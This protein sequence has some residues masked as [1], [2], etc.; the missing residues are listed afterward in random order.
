[1]KTASNERPKKRRF[2]ILI[3]TGVVITILFTLVVFS[4]KNMITMASF[5]TSL[6]NKITSFDICCDYLADVLIEYKSLPWLLDY[7]KGNADAIKNDERS[8]L[9]LDD[10][11]PQLTR[12]GHAMPTEVTVEEAMSMSPE[13][14]L[15]F[16]KYCY[17]STQ[18][19]C[20]L[21]FPDSEVT[22]VLFVEASDNDDNK[23][24][25]FDSHP[26]ETDIPL[27]NVEDGIMFDT[28]FD[29]TI[30]AVY[31]NV[32]RWSFTTPNDMYFGI[33][34]TFSEYEKLQGYECYALFESSNIYEDM[35]FVS[36]TRNSVTTMLII[37]FAIILLFLYFIVPR[38]LE[39]LKKCVAEYA[40][41][42]DVQLLTKNLSHIHTNNEIADFA[43]EFSNLAQEMERHVKEVQL[44]AEEKQ[45]DKT[46]LEIA[47]S[48]QKQMM[49]QVFPGN[50][51]FA[52][53]AA[54]KPA[55]E[56][57]GDFYD[58]YMIDDDHLAL[59]IA[60]VSGKGVASALFMAMSKIML[61]NRTLLGGTPS[62]ILTDVNNWICEGNEN[63]MFVTVWHAI[64]TISTGELV[65]ANAGHEY[66]AIRFGEKP[67]EL[68]KT[69]HS[70]VL[71]A[72]DDLEFEDETYILSSG[73]ALFVYTDGVTE[74]QTADEAM[75]GEER[76]TD[77]LRLCG[78][79]DTPEEIIAKVR[80]AID[81][82]TGSAPQYD[83]YTMLCL[84]MNRH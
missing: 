56:I 58:C 53:S 76:L 24:V 14:Q 59:T 69:E 25:I 66:P 74:A 34:D 17:L 27:G 6:T 62:Q 57:G 70:V 4:V 44:L 26:A 79:D 81:S 37:V 15:L 73:D 71:G 84:V 72:F 67:F 54:L 60:D 63:L 12:L 65:C 9:T 18:D 13:D 48:I 55:K 31:A 36:Y 51:S 45:K 46:E 33:K 38:P 52:L 83:D 42:K 20:T 21:M 1:M 75:F 28:A 82:Y 49:P 47:T 29:N 7:W 23:L 19:F 77:A 68:I 8:S 43:D 80:E 32:L 22:S 16:A 30:D 3:Q 11:Q 41:T 40:K 39:Q 61:K 2:K 35:T 64:L 10:I 50:D 5:S 78:S